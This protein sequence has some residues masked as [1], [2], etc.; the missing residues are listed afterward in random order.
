VLFAVDVDP[1]TPPVEIDRAQ[2]ELAL[3][4]LVS[5]AT[6]AMASAGTVTIGAQPDSIGRNG[7]SGA[8]QVRITVR[9]TGAGF[10]PSL[11][12][13]VTEPFYTTKGEGHTGLGLAM[14][15]GVVSQ[16]HGKLTFETNPGGGMVA[17]IFLPASARRPVEHPHQATEK[18]VTGGNE[19]ILVVEDESAVR[20]VMCRSL[21]ARG[22]EILEAKNGEDALLIAEKHN[23][24]IH[25]V[26][27]D[28][29]MPEM[30]GTELFSHLR[31]WYPTMRTLFISGYTKGA[32]PEE[33]LEAGGGAGFL[34]K[35]FTLDQLAAEVR[36]VIAL[37]RSTAKS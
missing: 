30:G 29:V 2:F 36:R 25:L 20:S 7:A 18:S 23:A 10:D 37:P 14:V 35:P 4:E 3:L 19:T 26:V 9:D 34:P 22:Y 31:R 21:R 5:N 17:S 27:T 6:D 32:I 33:A 24:P 28:V 11:A 13:R 15:D 12:S 1:R 8:G 16:H